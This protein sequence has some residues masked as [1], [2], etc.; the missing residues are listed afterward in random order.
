M[1]LD[2]VKNTLLPSILRNKKWNRFYIL[3]S[4]MQEKKNQNNHSKG[5]ITSI[6][7]NFELIDYFQMEL[8]SVG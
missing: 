1:T 7:F 6:Y 2:N 3:G 8:I 4:S 5:N